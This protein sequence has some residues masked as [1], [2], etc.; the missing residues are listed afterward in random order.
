[1]QLTDVT[2]VP[3]V[4]ALTQI[5]KGFGFVPDRFVPV[6]P[7]LLGVLAGLVLNHANYLTGAVN[8]LFIGLTAAGVYRGV[9]VGLGA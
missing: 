3:L 2:A 9:K 7:T 1:M 5:I 4:M 6:I 8:G